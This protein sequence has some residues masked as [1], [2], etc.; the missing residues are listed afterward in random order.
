[1]SRKLNSNPNH[2]ILLPTSLIYL[3]LPILIFVVGWLKW[4]FS[5]PIAGLV[6]LTFAM[7]MHGL[8]QDREPEKSIEKIEGKD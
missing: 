7:M 4:Y 3:A 2:N 8:A 1:M 5:I 6:L